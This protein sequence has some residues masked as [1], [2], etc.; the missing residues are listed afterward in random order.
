MNHL[1]GVQCP[2]TLSEQLAALSAKGRVA[3]IGQNDKSQQ[4]S[5]LVQFSF[6]GHV[7][8]VQAWSRVLGTAVAKVYQ[9]CI[10][11]GVFS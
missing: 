8:K 4:S 10:D 1:T 9:R 2:A 5:Y 3:I 6:D 7:V 11:Q